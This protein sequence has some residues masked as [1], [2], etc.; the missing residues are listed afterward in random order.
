VVVARYGSA[1]GDQVLAVAAEHF[2][3]A[4]LTEDELYRCDGPVL[5]GARAAAAAIDSVREE[6]G[7]FA[8][9]KLEKSFAIGSRSV[10]LPISTSWV[11]FPIVPP[12]DA[13]LKK[14]ELFIATQTSH[15]HV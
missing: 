5:L 2:R 8:G 11:I 9:R 6:V 7:R 13:L 4:L 1:I 14:V 10:S 15:D 3:T 12:L